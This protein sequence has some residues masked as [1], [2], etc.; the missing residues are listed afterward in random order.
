MKA[1]VGLGNPGEKYAGTRHNV[2][3]AV[4]D[5][6]A[7]RAA[8]RF[9]TAPAEALIARWRRPDEGVLLV[10]P[11]TF[12]NNSGQAI[13][14]LARYFKIDVGDLLVIVDEVQLPLGRIR[15]RARGSAGGHNGLK[16]AI[17]HLGDQ[18]AR[19]R[20]GVGR[21]EQRRN[22]ADHVLARFDR[23][24]A[25]EVERMIARAA[26]AADTFITSGIEAVMNG[27]NGGDPATTE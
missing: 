2:G 16:S 19:L 13:G 17:V 8:V 20:L 1:I 12:M 25:A 27:Y 11:L 5:E 14:E 15:A 23:D 26:D 22:L 6:I 18:F 21:G 7:R 3:F 9:E 24:E 10:K 4:V